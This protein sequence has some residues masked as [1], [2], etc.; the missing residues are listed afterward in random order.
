MI[1]AVIFVLC[2]VSGATAGTLLGWLVAQRAA[3][4]QEPSDMLLEQAYD[5]GYAH[6]REDVY[7]E[8]LADSDA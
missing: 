1:L 7:A 3:T 2:F 4:V 5:D 6:G 8:A